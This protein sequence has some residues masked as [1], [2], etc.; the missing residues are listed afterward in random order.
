MTPTVTLQLYRR[1][2]LKLTSH[3]RCHN[4]MF[5]KYTQICIVK[6][7]IHKINVNVGPN[8]HHRYLE[9]VSRGATVS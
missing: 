6:I 1:T 9:T 4:Q 5:Q 8:F 3:L 7:K 2:F